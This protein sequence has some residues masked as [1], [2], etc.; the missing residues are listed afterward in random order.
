MLTTKTHHTGHAQTTHPRGRMLRWLLPAVLVCA[1][2]IASACG[3][4]DGDDSGAAPATTETTAAAPATTEG[5]LANPDVELEAVDEG[6]VEVATADCPVFEDERGGIFQEYQNQFDRCHPFQSLDSFCVA[7]E[8]PDVA[9]VATDPGITENSISVVH[10]RTKLEELASIGFATDVGDPAGMFNT[11][12]WYVNNVC[13]GVNGRMIDLKLVETAASGANID[14]LRNAACIEATEDHNAVVVINSSGFQGTANLCLVEDHQTAF[15]STQGQSGEFMDRGEGRLIS[16]SPTLEE[17]LAFL[18][19][20]L[21]GSGELEGKTIGVIVPDTPGQLESV[22]RGLVDPLEAAGLNVAVFDTIGCG[23]QVSCTEGNSESVSRLLDE[24]VDVLF[25]TLNVVS[26]PQYLGEMV[27]QGFEPGDVTFYNSDFNSQASNIVVSKIVAFGG[28]AAGELYNGAIIIDDADPAAFHEPGWEPR[29]F[30]QMCDDT[31]NEYV[32]NVEIND[33]LS[34]PPHDPY[35][36]TANTP[37]GMV[38]SVCAQMRLT[39]RALYDAGPNPTREDV[40]E[41]LLNLGAIDFN[42]MI[43][44]SIEPGKP[45]TTDVIHTLMFTYPCASGEEFGFGDEGT[46]IVNAP[47]DRWFRVQR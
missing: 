35:D 40:N 28:Q 21:I 16:M 15:I 36:P 3:S 7:H 4:D 6:Q 5:A 41:A 8:A 12:A 46:C 42:N 39:M 30:N 29:K 24:G 2:L 43:P 10:I 47:D 25:P 9:R 31:Y 34:Q 26:L 17:S 38:A 14:E 19:N 33:S 37:H 18:V 44:N 22:E 20:T 32:S 11:F 45:Q 13:G 1:A 23:G 27:N